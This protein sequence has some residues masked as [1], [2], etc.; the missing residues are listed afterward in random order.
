[1]NHNFIAPTSDAFCRTSELPDYFRM[2][3]KAP[4]KKG[5]MGRGR[6]EPRVKGKVRAPLGVL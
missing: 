5:L 1:M 2:R 3:V 4:V 6:K